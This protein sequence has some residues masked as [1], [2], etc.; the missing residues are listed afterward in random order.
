MNLFRRRGKQK[1]PYEPALARIEGG[2]IKRGLSAPE[3]SVLLGR[4]LNL[5]LTLVLFEMLRKGFLVQEQAIPLTVAIA[6]PFQIK[7]ANLSLNEIKEQRRGAAQQLPA[8]LA[9]Y[10]EAFLEVLETQHGRASKIHFSIAVQP[11]IRFVAGRVGGY[12]LAETRAYYEALIERAPKEARSDGVLTIEREKV[13]DRNFGWL[14]MHPDFP[15]LLDQDDYSYQPVWWRKDPSLVPDKS[16]ATWARQVI[17]EMAANPS[18][19]SVKIELGEEEDLL[20]ATLMNDIARATFY[21]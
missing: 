11:V 1:I 6:P 19:E 12:S 8:A 4:P 14:L 5:S 21:G 9:L 3:A 17:D 18:L 15:S 2:G 10:E 16:F 13:F 20:S 7:R